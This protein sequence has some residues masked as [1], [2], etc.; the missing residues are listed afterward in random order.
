MKNFNSTNMIQASQWCFNKNINLEEAL[1]W[2]QR[3]VGGFNGQRSYVS[4][5]N[6]ATGY[7][8]LNRLQQA[9]SVMT[10]ALVLGNINQAYGYGRSLL[11]QKRQEKALEVFLANKTKYGDIYLVNSGLMYGYSAKGDFKKAI[12]AADKTL[13]QAPNENTKSAV[14]ALLI[15][16]KDGKDINQ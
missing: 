7:E 10:E 11:Q 4:L 12:I 9:D 6:L 13:A 15:K 8:K 16:L 3:A 1:V 14:S 5:R 2:A